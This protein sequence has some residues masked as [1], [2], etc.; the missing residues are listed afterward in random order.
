MRHLQNG[1]TNGLSPETETLKRE[2]ARQAK[3]VVIL[4]KT[5]EEMELRIESQKQTLNSRDES[6]KKL[7]EMLKSKGLTVKHIEDDRMEQERMRTTIVEEE[8]RIMQLEGIL[9]Q[10]D[11]EISVLKEVSTH[12]IIW[13]IPQRSV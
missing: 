1:K 12:F 13:V 7:L 10:R 2:K 11:L 8:R 9:E 3:E 6:I 4:R 5:V